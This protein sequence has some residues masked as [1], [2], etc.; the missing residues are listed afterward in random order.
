MT[1]SQ[2]VDALIK[3]IEEVLEA[4]IKVMS[5]PAKE[6]TRV[7]PTWTP[8]EILCHLIWWHQCTV[9]GI[10]S[11]ASGGAPF[12]FHATTDDLNHRS[13]ARSSGKTVEILVGELNGL[14][15]RLVKAAR[16]ISDPDATVLINNEGTERSTIERLESIPGHWNSHIADCNSA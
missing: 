2:K 5:D 6:E 11:V 4:G 10:E 12:Q 15:E 16:S 3:P 14:Q 13:V 8:R 7:Y 9:E 1:T